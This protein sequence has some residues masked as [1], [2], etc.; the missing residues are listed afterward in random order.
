MVGAPD[1]FV[2]SDTNVGHSRILLGMH[3]SDLPTNCFIFFV[4]P[5][6]FVF[7]TVCSIRYT[8][9]LLFWAFT[10]CAIPGVVPD[11]IHIFRHR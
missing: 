7:L 8:I 2:Y 4:V 11:T 9:L 3:F 6:P 10:L 5:N 1:V